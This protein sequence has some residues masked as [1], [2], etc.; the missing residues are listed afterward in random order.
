MTQLQPSAQY[1]TTNYLVPSNGQTHCVSFTGNFSSIP[2]LIDWRQ[3]AIDNQKFQP[4]GVF[5][6]NSA[7]T[8]PLV[9]T[10]LPIGY[11]VV[12][13]AG[14]TS[15]QQFPAPNGQTCTITGDPANV[16]TVYFVDFPVLPSGL[17]ATITNTVNT[18]IS[19]ISPGVTIPVQPTASAQG[20]APYNDN[21]AQWG[22]TNTSLGQ[23]AMAASV[24]VTVA[25]DQGPLTV[26]VAPAA[27]VTYE[28]ASSGNQA[29]AA[30]T[31]SLAGAVG[32]STWV[33]GFEITAGGATAA[34][35]VVATLTGVLGGTQSY[36]FAVPAGATVGATP[37]VV[38]FNPPLPSSAANT[39]ITLTLPALGAGNTNAI[40]N[41]H[42]YTQ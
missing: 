27:G 33:T 42:G 40:V 10:I 34:S 8:T 28:S 37:L 25:S 7:G 12:C 36:V 17:S 26:N 31:A 38:E 2:A 13:G 11:K 18:N 22:G 32:K 15:Q 30:A 20:N 19:S 29:N 41:I 5:I 39:A 1:T 3:F 24:P 14:M 21:I 16:A 9:I 6:D 4:Q 35:L 23:K